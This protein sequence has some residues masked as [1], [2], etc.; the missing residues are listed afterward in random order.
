MPGVIPW[1]IRGC[2]IDLSGCA[3][4]ELSGTRKGDFFHLLHTPYISTSIVLRSSSL[5]VLIF[6]FLQ[7]FINPS[8]YVR[9]M[10]S[11]DR[12]PDNN[13]IEREIF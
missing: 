4:L 2:R 8:G 1:D 9:A 5:G 11:Y 13:S 7:G 3:S 10:L 6:L 12:K